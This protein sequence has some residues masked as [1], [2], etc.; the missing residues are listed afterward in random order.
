M[1]NGFIYNLEDSSDRDFYNESLLK[2][3]AIN[4]INPIIDGEI[5]EYKPEV[6]KNITYN[7]FFLRYLSESDLSLIGD[8]VEDEFKKHITKTKLTLN[9]IDDDGNPIKQPYNNQYQV[10]QPNN[11][12]EPISFFQKD[13][14]R[15]EISK[16]SPFL[17]NDIIGDSLLKKP[18]K[19]GLPIY[20]NTFTLPYWGNTSA[21]IKNKL[22]Y[23]NSSF[24]YKSFLLMEVYDSPNQLNQ[25]RLFST[26]IFISKR[27]NAT[28]KNSKFNINY[29]RPSFNLSENIDGYSLFFLGDYTQ[30]ELYIRYSFWDALNNTKIELTPSSELKTNR[31]W[32]FQT[33]NFKQQ[34]RYLK[35]V[36][37]YDNKTY[38]LYEF[39]DTTIDYTDEK[40]DFDLYEFGIDDFYQKPVTNDKPINSSNMLPNQNTQTKIKF[41]IKNLFINDYIGNG[42]NRLK[43]LNDSDYINLKPF[44]GSVD[45][46]KLYNNYVGNLKTSV[47]GSLT[48]K[49]IKPSWLNKDLK[50]VEVNLKSFILKNTDTTNWIIRDIRF[51]DVI[52]KLGEQEYING[53]NNQV[54]SNW[55]DPNKILVSEYIQPINNSSAYKYDEYD[56]TKDFVKNSLLNLDNFKYLLELISIERY[57]TNQFIKSENIN[58][59]SNR[60]NDKSIINFLD[61]CFNVTNIKYFTNHNKTANYL[62]YAINPQTKKPD[63]DNSEIYNYIEQLSL[64]VNNLKGTD[65]YGEIIDRALGLL[66]S[67]YTNQSDRNGLCLDYVKRITQNSI[68]SDQTSN[69]LKFLQ[70]IQYKNNRLIDLTQGDLVLNLQTPVDRLGYEIR[71]YT[72]TLFSKFNGSTT[73]L[74]GVENKIDLNLFIGDAI[75]D[76]LNNLNNITISGKYLISIFNEISKDIKYINIPILININPKN[77]TTFNKPN[78][79]P[80]YDVSNIDNTIQ[81]KLR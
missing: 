60:F 54:K 70:N 30:N 32:L 51:N 38:R 33:E 63:Y 20:Y 67:Y 49:T 43:T 74:N 29:E 19:S 56:F 22:L 16:Q 55:N 27:Y 69:F 10:K 28:E 65:V 79:L 77:T 8:Y 31:K 17:I 71:D 26:P 80:T 41:N 44:I 53:I 59:S 52:I 75:V 58:G 1:L 35:C 45:I 24:F 73:L 46:I 66:N 25:N 61:L 78:Q 47:F 62:G 21:W 18:K 81:F 7:L 68:D 48:K 42:E 6:S 4:S 9:L 11:V 72:V 5:Y 57:N 64:G 13:L 76:K 15:L 34:Y 50:L 2:K 14:S 23:T 39:N 3:S 37:N 12:D 40:Y 36:L